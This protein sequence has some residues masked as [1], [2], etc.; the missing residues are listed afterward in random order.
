MPIGCVDSSRHTRE[1]RYRAIAQVTTRSVRERRIMRAFS[2]PDA[3]WKARTFVVSV[4]EKRQPIAASGKFFT[5]GVEGRPAGVVRA[6]HPR[7]GG[8][9]R[10]VLPGRVPFVG[11][12]MA[13]L[14][15]AVDLKSNQTITVSPKAAIISRLIDIV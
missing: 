1:S 11:A 15:D 4:R 12:G 5:N 14:A 6:C 7:A 8:P 10:R 2:K 3:V 9:T 13:K